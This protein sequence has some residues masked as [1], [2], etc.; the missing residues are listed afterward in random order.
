MNITKEKLRR[1]IQEEYDKLK[2]KGLIIESR[3][4]RNTD[5]EYDKG[6]NAGY[7]GLKPIENNPDY[8]DGYAQGRD[9]AAEDDV[10][11]YGNWENSRW[12]RTGKNWER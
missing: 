12:D 1:I 11:E 9:D 7:E 10:S 6:Y 2:N 4:L 8:L 3:D 5:E